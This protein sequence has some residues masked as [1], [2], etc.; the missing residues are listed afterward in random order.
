MSHGPSQFKLNNV[1]RAF[2]AAKMAGVE[3]LRVDIDREGKISIFP[4][5]VTQADQPSNEWD[6]PHG[7]T[8]SK[9]RP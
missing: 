7:K 8:S 9:L 3:V 2:T 4:A 6:T 1:K 5:K